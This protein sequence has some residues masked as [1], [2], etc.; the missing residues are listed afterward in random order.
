[1]LS[2]LFSSLTASG[3]LMW[4]GEKSLIQYNNQNNRKKKFKAN[5]IMQKE[6]IKRRGTYSTKPKFSETKVKLVLK[7][8]EDKIEKR[9]DGSGIGQWKLCV[10]VH[11][12]LCLQ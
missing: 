10:C 12:C 9:A 11:V 2:I 5:G 1:M 4:I 6:K 8:L 3:G 7:D